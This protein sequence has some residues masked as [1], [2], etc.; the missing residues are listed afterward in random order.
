[1]AGVKLFH[2]YKV[3]AF[4]VGVL[5]VALAVGML[6]KYGLTEGTVWQLRG[7]DLTR[8][9]AFIHGWI[10]IVYVVVAFVLSQRAG[11]KISFLVLLLV[12]GLVPVLI[13]FVER[14]V[15]ARLRTEA[16]DLV[17]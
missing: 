8:V 3:L 1:V 17:S 10:Y 5:L 11:W 2:V 16:P 4:V 12:A 6:L 15:E 7:D 13:F 9:V 14:R